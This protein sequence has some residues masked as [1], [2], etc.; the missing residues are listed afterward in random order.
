MFSFE[1]QNIPSFNT[2][3]TSFFLILKAKTS[4]FNIPNIFFPPSK[5]KKTSTLNTQHKS[6]F[7]IL[8]AR[9]NLSQ[10]TKYLYSSFCRQNILIKHQTPL[11]FYTCYLNQ[12]WCAE[13]IIP[14]WNLPTSLYIYCNTAKGL[15]LLCFTIMNYVLISNSHFNLIC[16]W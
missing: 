12:R 7:H 3:H 1:K 5:S 2:Q 14:C 9:N 15:H 6:F 16:F 10:N 11:S 4:L 13:H 8:N